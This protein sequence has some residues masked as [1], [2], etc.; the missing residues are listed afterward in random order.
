[1]YQLVEQ[2]FSFKVTLPPEQASNASYGDKSAK[3]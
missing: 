1:V 2:H 3:P